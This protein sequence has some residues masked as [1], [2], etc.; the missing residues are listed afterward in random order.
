MKPGER[1]QECEPSRGEENAYKGEREDPVNLVG[2]AFSEPG[3]AASPA[4]A[5]GLNVG[6][7]RHGC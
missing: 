6:R 7:H 5:D 3:S 1:A 4:A 2:E